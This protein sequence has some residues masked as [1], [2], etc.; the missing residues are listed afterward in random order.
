MPSVFTLTAAE[1]CEWQI[2]RGK[3]TLGCFGS[4]R[5][6]TKAARKKGRG[7]RVSSDQSLSG[8]LGGNF[9]SERWWPHKAEADNQ[10]GF[11]HRALR[12]GNCK[13]ALD[14]LVSAAE[15]STS[16]WGVAEREAGRQIKPSSERGAILKRTKDNVSRLQT[17]FRRFCVLKRPR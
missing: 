14:S 5:A 11:G 15:Y 2:Q 1:Y 8:S 10:I 4:K 7:W 3:R 12:K 16:A 6:A 13:K 9:F 17:D